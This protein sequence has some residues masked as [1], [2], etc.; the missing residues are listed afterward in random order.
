MYLTMI[1]EKQW[2]L[3]LRTTISVSLRVKL[4]E[5]LLGTVE[6]SGGRSMPGQGGITPGVVGFSGT[7]DVTEADGEVRVIGMET[8]FHASQSRIDSLNELAESRH[9]STRNG[10]LCW[11]W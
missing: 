1:T 7:Q 3:A 8:P 6:R 5:C 10:P 4:A 9:E 2:P 11:S